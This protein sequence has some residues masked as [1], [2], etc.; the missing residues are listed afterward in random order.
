M[1]LNTLAAVAYNDS[2]IYVWIC[3]KARQHFK[4]H[5]KIS[6]GNSAAALIRYVYRS[7]HLAGNKSRGF[8]G[9]QRTWKNKHMVSYSYFSVRSP[10]S[11]K[12]HLNSSN[13]FIILSRFHVCTCSPCLMS[14]RAYPILQPYFITASPFLMSLR[15]AL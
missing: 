10:I 3:R 9:A 15:A 12:F 11:F 2:S 5:F 8:T 14:S 7:W 4:S 1:R 6:C 13:H